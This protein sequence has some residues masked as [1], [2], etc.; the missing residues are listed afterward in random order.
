[1]RENSCGRVV[2]DKSFTKCRYPS[3]SSLYSSL[4]SKAGVRQEA[5]TYILMHA[6]KE[7][8]FKMAA[9]QT[10]ISPSSGS[11]KSVATDKDKETL[12]AVLQFLKNKNLTVSRAKF[13]RIL[14]K[15]S[16][17]N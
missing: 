8:I 14:S 10:T 11:T 12:R 6:G 4:S 7:S 15:R 1:M 5:Q 2:Q 9:N 17:V 13:C 3:P 16:R